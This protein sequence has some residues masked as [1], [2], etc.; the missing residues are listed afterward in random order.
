MQRRI[1]VLQGSKELPAPLHALLQEETF[2]V[3]HIKGLSNAGKAILQHRPSAVL[4]EVERY[5]QEVEEL[6]WYLSNLRNPQM[7]RRLILVRHAPAEDLVRALEQGADDV[8]LS[9]LSSREL[10]A[11]LNSLL[12]SQPL[13]KEDQVLSAGGL[14]LFRQS[15]EVEVKSERKKLSRTEFNLLAFF[16]EHAGQVLSRDVLLENLWFDWDELDYPRTVDVYICRLREK[17]EEDPAHPV[18]LVT[19]RGHGYFFVDSAA[20][21]QRRPGP[22]EARDSWD[23][24]PDE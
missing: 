23:G 10:H 18:R 24:A 19:R 2:E 1:M 6:L 11:R 14:H 5:S 3:R 9:S 15:L 17:I 8:L 4:I 7:I 20:A 12:R 13:V 16:M 22:K 21:D